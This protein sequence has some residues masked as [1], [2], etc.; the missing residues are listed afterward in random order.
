MGIYYWG[1]TCKS[2]LIPLY[3]CQKHVIR[4]INF[5]DRFTHI[6]SHYLMKWKSWIYMKLMCPKF[7]VLCLNVKWPPMFHNIFKLKQPNK[8]VMR[9]TGAGTVLEPKCK[10]RSDQF[11]VTFCSPYLWTKL[12]VRNSDFTQTELVSSFRKNVKRFC[13]PLKTFFNLSNLHN[14]LH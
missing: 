5:K 7:Y 11:N 10:T 1:S 6:Q 13:Q 14:S 9:S 8:Y 3:R 12:I 2:T 4:V